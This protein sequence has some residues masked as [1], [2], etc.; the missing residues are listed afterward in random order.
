MFAAHT[1]APQ[2]FEIDV[3]VQGDTKL[4]FPEDF[5]LNL[6]NLQAGDRDV[7]FSDESGRGTILSDDAGAA[8]VGNML[9]IFGSDEVN[10]K[11]VVRETSSKFKVKFNNQNLPQ[12]P[13][14]GVTQVKI[15]TFGGKDNVNLLLRDSLDVLIETG[16]DDDTVRREEQGPIGN[17]WWRRRRQNHGG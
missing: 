14:A 4:E 11:V 7:T 1:V 17:P 16:D 3:N 9:L 5:S 2:T 12:I 6:S 15:F 8:V 13:K 10:D